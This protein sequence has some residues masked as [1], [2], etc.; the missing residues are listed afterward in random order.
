MTALGA[1]QRL[2]LEIG[3]F[4]FSP[5]TGRSFGSEWGFVDDIVC[6]HRRDAHPSVDRLGIHR[7]CL[8]E[9]VLSLSSI[10]RGH[11]LVVPGPA[12]RDLIARI[13]IG[14]LFLLDPAPN[15]RDRDQFKVERARQSGGNLGARR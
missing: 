7:Q 1:E 8:L 3:C 14:R 10:F 2:L 15:S 13:E 9:G 5:N 11:G 4:R 12:A 6:E